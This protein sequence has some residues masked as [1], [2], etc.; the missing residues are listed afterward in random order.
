MS[1]TIREGGLRQ[2]VSEKHRTALAK[3]KVKEK[4]KPGWSSEMP[5]TALFDPSLSRHGQVREF[6]SQQLALLSQSPGRPEHAP[7]P[8]HGVLMPHMS[9]P[10]RTAAPRPHQK[11]AL[12]PKSPP[13]RTRRPS[14]GFPTPASSSTPTRRPVSAPASQVQQRPPSSMPLAAAPA[15]RH[16]PSARTHEEHTAGHVRSL[17]VAHLR[18][19]PAYEWREEKPHIRL[20]EQA[21]EMPGAALIRRHVDVFANAI[22]DNILEDVAMRLTE[23]EQ[24]PLQS[25]K[26]VLKQATEKLSTLENVLC[27]KY[28]IPIDP[29]LRLEGHA[30]GSTHDPPHHTTASPVLLSTSAQLTFA[31]ARNA[32]ASPPLSFPTANRSSHPVSPSQQAPALPDKSITRSGAS[33]AQSKNPPYTAPIPTV[34]EIASSE[35]IAPRNTPHDTAPPTLSSLPVHHEDP[36]EDE[37]GMGSWG[38]PRSFQIIG[39]SGSANIVEEVAS[40]PSRQL[41]A[42]EREMENV[43]AMHLEGSG[44]QANRVMHVSRDLCKRMDLYR[45]RFKQHCVAAREGALD[46]TLRTWNIWPSLGTDILDD[47]ITA[48]ARE[49]DDA[50]SLSVDQLVVRETEKI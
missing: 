2:R 40:D 7:G 14:R 48:V 15:E 21:T 26:P 12:A 41:R 1:A 35:S 17:P 24:R 31:T 3:R 50:V 20:P 33:S 34:G 32:D 46:G 19:G 9:P 27:A 36:R 28:G 30:M 44:L 38:P 42:D 49:M 47:V 39:G 29:S 5:S 18:R 37:S 16:L 23:L 10:R 8:Q 22:L 45:Y 43:P 6:R 11:V 4:E 13:D 25:E